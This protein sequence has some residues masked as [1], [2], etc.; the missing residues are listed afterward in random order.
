MLIPADKHPSI[1]CFSSDVC[2]SLSASERSLGC[3]I[4]SVYVCLWARSG[5]RL[6]V[7]LWV[8]VYFCLYVSAFVN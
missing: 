2:L 7:Y 6:L 1:W 3:S 8:Y 4:V 5:A